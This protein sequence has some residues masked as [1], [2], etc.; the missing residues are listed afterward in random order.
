MRL[1]AGQS[2][3]ERQLAHWD[4]H[5]ARAQVAEP[6]DTLAVCYYDGPYVCLWP[7]GTQDYQIYS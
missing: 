4:S 5:A 2:R 6:Q 3:V 1:D 7:A